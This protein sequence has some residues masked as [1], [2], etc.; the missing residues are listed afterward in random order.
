MV[1]CLYPVVGITLKVQVFF[2]HLNFILPH[3]CLQDCFPFYKQTFP[4]TI[5]KG[6]TNSLWGCKEADQAT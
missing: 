6:F 3:V 2:L 4:W 5:P 1:S